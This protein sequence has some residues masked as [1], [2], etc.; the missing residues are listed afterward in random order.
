[1][2]NYTELGFKKIRAPLKLMKL[3]NSH[4]DKNRHNMKAEKWFA[5]NTYTNHWAAPTYMISVEDSGFRGAGPALKREIWEAAKDTIEEWIG[6]ELKPTSLYGIRVYTEGAVLNPHVDRLPLV[7]SAIV[8]VAQD[9]DEDWPLEVYGHDGRVYNVTMHPGDMVLYES[10]S[11]M[12]GRPFSM[13]GRYYANIFIHFEPTG[14]PLHLNSQPLSHQELPPYIRKNTPEEQ[15]W[16]TQHSAGWDS[17][18]AA[19]APIHQV[20]LAAATGDFQTLT[21][22][23]KTEKHLLHLKDKNGW[24]PIHE[25]ARGGHESILRFL[26][27]KGADVNERTNYGTGGTALYWVQKFHGHNHPAAD[28]LLTLGAVNIEP[29]L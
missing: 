3:L 20:H 16:K 22:I 23:E 9:V 18:A 17:P 26:V 11:L 29:E 10:H 19:A 12:H 13:K 5:G 8:N 24:Q 27:E 25:A 21:D 6:M 1:M 15:H 14:R 28:Y 7:S 2:T 4:W